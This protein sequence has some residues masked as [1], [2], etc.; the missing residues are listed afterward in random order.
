MVVPANMRREMMG[1]A[2]ATHIGIEGCIR[3][4]WESIYWPHMIS[5][6]KDYIS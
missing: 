5:E 1:V 3:R 6:L 4:A 2:H